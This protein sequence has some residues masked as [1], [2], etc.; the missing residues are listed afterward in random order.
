MQDKTLANYERCRKPCP[1]GNECIL[2]DV[3]HTLCVCPDPR[4]WCHSSD[5]YCQERGKENG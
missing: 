3:K 5:R 4:C 1:G 2:Q